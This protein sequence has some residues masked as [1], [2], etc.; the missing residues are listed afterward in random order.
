[1]N[2]EDRHDLWWWKAKGYTLRCTEMI[3]IPA[4]S[5]HILFLRSE[6]E[7]WGTWDVENDLMMLN[8]KGASIVIYNALKGN[9]CHLFLPSGLRE[10]FQRNAFTHSW[11]NGF[12]P[13][14]W[15]VSSPNHLPL[16]KYLLT[17]APLRALCISP[18]LILSTTP[19]AHD[20]LSF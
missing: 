19:K 10:V 13:C 8:K 11:N 12:S 14:I 6:V 18:H 5:T 15:S 16:I 1:M 2:W 17:G 4:P 9:H 7:Q 3:L 20:A